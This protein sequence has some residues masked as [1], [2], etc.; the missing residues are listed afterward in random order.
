M[1]RRALCVIWLPGVGRGRVGPE[2]AERQPRC[3]RSV[4]IARVE[5][6]H[7]WLRGQRFA[8]LH[9]MGAR[10]SVDGRA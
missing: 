10:G 1:L 7:L 6:G 4:L 9:T 3:Q 5:N 8:R 2:G